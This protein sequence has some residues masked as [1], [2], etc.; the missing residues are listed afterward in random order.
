MSNIILINNVTLQSGIH[1]FGPIIIPSSISRVVL[2]VDRT[3]WIDPA[4]A[5]SL[6]LDFSL[7]GVIWASQSPSQQTDPYP[8]TITAEG[9]TIKDRNGILQHTYISAVFP[10]VG[11]TT[12]QLKGSLTLMGGNLTTTVTLT[13]S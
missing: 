6:T 3:N 1:N 4:V 2:T 8:I 13:T 11:N 12:R 10:S 5:L 7:D 9:G